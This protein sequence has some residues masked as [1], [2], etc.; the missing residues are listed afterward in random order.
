MEE[1]GIEKI[2]W[3]IA[4]PGFGQI[5]NRKY[6]KG[7]LLI[8]L[9]LLINVQSNLNEIIIWSFHGDTQLAVEQTN[10]R[11]LMFYPCIYIFAIWDA[12]RDAQDR[13]TPFAFLPFVCSA[14]FGTIGVIYSPTLKIMGILLG[15]IWLSI[16]FLVVG[17]GMGILIRMV[18][19]KFILQKKEQT[20]TEEATPRDN[21]E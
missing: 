21:K 3:S 14:Y 2:L 11:W 1:N 8:V 10:F 9:E 17:L 19:L 20:I 12:Y 7:L 18:L 13:T 5:L 4:L 6:F 15:P 16:L